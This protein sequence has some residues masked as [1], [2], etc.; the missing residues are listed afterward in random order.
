[1][2]DTVTESVML[3]S[4]CCKW[5]RLRDHIWLKGNIRKRLDFNQNLNFNNLGK[6]FLFLTFLE[7]TLKQFLG[8]QDKTINIKIST[9]KILPRTNMSHYMYSFTNNLKKDKVNHKF[10]IYRRMGG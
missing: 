2:N 7:K 10:S 1:M 8:R 9:Q 5:K 3:L 4:C 6:S